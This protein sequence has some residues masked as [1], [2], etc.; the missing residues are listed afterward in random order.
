MLHIIESAPGQ[1]FNV[2]AGHGLQHIHRMTHGFLIA[3]L[4]AAECFVSDQ[5]GRQVQLAAGHAKN[6]VV[7]H[8]HGDGHVTDSGVA[9]FIQADNIGT[10]VTGMDIDCCFRADLFYAGGNR[11]AAAMRAGNK[12]KIQRILRPEGTG[13]INRSDNLVLQSQFLNALGNQSLND[14]MAAA[15]TVSSCLNNRFRFLINR[16]PIAPPWAEC[17]RPEFPCSIR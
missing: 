16:H 14:T 1:K 2:E 17:S 11:S 4:L 7:Y 6:A 12:L 8:N 5:G 3:A 15:S 13:N 10:A 9:G